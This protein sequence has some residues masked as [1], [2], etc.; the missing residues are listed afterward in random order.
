MRPTPKK[1]AFAPRFP[2]P[3]VFP[4]GVRS[5]NFDELV[6][7]CEANWEKS[8]DLLVLIHLAKFFASLRRADLANLRTCSPVTCKEMICSMTTVPF[9]MDRLAASFQSERKGV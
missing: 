5:H 9:K 7:A 3:F 8:L 1:R 4:C 2:K 6:Q